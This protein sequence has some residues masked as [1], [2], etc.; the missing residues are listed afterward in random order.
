MV[1]LGKSEVWAVQY[2]PEFDLEQLAQL[3]TLYADDMVTQGFFNSGDDLARYVG[4]LRELAAN[5][6]D[7]LSATYIGRCEKMKKSP[8]ASDWNGVWVLDEK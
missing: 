3:Y 1:P 2:H 6:G 4:L 8:P 5:P 7:K